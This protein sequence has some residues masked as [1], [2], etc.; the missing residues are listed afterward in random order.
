[1]THRQS[2][3]SGNVQAGLSRM[4]YR[5]ALDLGTNSIGWAMVRLN[6]EDTPC[7]VIRAGARIFAGGRNPKDGS[8]LAVSRRLARGLRRRRDRLLRR[9]A[10]MMRLLIQHGFFPV[11]DAD[12]RALELLDPYRLRT[13]GLDEEL[14][15][16]EFARALFHINQ[17]RGFK[18]NRR[19]D[20][21]ESDSGP[22]KAAISRVRQ[23]LDP[24]GADGRARTVGELLYR[25]HQTGHTVRAR[26]RENRVAAANGRAKIDKSY[27][28]YI[29]R[30][31]IEDEF[32]ALWAAQAARNAQLYTDAAQGDLRD[33]LLYQRK[34]KPVTP[35]RCTL[36]P[37]EARA[38][39]ALP[40]TQRFRIYQEVNNLR[41]LDGL[42]EAPLGTQQRDAVVQEL[43]RRG[44]LTFDGI[45]KLL[46]LAGS[47]RFNIEDAK[48]TELK[49]NATSAVL[50]S[51]RA[52]GAAWHAF[53]A[54]RQSAIVT[55]LLTEESESQLVAWLQ[56]E[57]GVDALV[58]AHLAEL[59]LPAG[60]GS[61]CRQ[62]LARI[63]P[64]LQEH[65]ISFA[66]AA[67]RAGF[68][69]SQLSANQA[70]PGHTFELEGVNT[71]T[72]EIRT[73]HVFREL[74]YY[75]EALQRHVGFGSGVDTDSPERRFGRIANPTVHIGLNQVRKV[76][77][78]LI[79]KYGHPAE[80]IIEVARDLKQSREDKEVEQDR[81][82]ENQRRNERLRI[83]AA[84]LVGS[85]NRVKTA[86][87]QKLILWE[88]LSPN[89]L[90]RRCPYSGAPISLAMVLTD[91]VEV[92]H[93]LPFSR[94]LDDSLNNKTVALR[95]A[96]RI[97]GNRTPWEARGDFEAQGWSFEAIVG[98]AD[99]MPRSKRYRFRE[100]GYARWLRDDKNFLARALNDTRYL[101][102]VA[103]EYL[104]LVCPQSTR[105][106]PGQ[107]TAMLRAKFGLNDIL[108][109]AGE[110]NRNDHRHH[111]VDA[112]VIAVTDQGLLQRFAH[113]S[114][115]A[116]E[117]HLG[118]LVE[119]MPLPWP[120]YREHVGRSV[121]GVRVSHKP[122]HG[123]EGA[124]HNDTAYAL[125]GEG[126]VRSHK[127]ID[128]VRTAVE[129]NLQVI[130]ISAPAAVRRHGVL[131]DGRPRPYK[132]YD[133]NSNYCIEVV[134]DAE[135]RWRG[136]VV[137]TFAAYQIVRQAGNTAPLRQPLVSMSG[138][139]LVMRLVIGDT[140]RLIVDDV[141]HMMRVAKIN[142]EGQLALAECH[143][144][145]VDARNRD[146]ESG[147]A[148]TYKT[149]GSLKVA[150]GRRVTISPIGDIHDPAF[151]T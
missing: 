14:T 122:D 142:S 131:E 84:E 76:V 133:G 10:R 135:G 144:A 11:E 13:R 73:W 1:M 149:A 38:P 137:S 12:R 120:T 90:E 117:Q 124:M 48:R 140:V 67:Q 147:F 32:D 134:R 50:A 27:D 7:A 54:D 132:G 37:E 74:P 62:A 29:D 25:R 36:M 111:A 55:R 75:G 89:P 83:A 33:C 26:Y 150:R 123:H 18:S 98:R 85:A 109:L 40:A 28:L 79:A 139:P 21:S 43:E 23:D 148:Y 146:K 125:V 88:E 102:R 114:Q 77:N 59:S 20:K 82:A 95:A 86:D 61:L 106:I 87:I 19:T 65:V 112:C 92:E 81:Q 121:H 4:R 129:K 5:L 105:V 91:A 100:D 47:S 24:T 3:T 56:E 107:M 34:L 31:M 71:I 51:K 104:S 66:E 22:L 17:R 2:Q 116:S 145:N 103:R 60:Y 110:K 96:N 45:R 6:A 136:E 151:R 94:T 138:K 64:E 127:V 108:G 35:G 126:R 58:A 72:G 49:G 39:L 101:S 44:K 78:A 113:A 46:E 119:A 53:T 42:N 93:I 70:V 99:A 115:A 41:I 141:L 143:E 63:L 52:F 68:H 97:K 15:G 16:P 30:R 9:K 128:G 69:H 118:R 8:S 80:V 57:T 130:P